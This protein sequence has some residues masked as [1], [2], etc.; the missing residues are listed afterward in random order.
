MHSD[1]SNQRPL[2]NVSEG[3]CQPAWSPDGRTVLYISP[4]RAQADVYTNT[5]ASIYAQDVNAQGEAVGSASRLIAVFGGAFDPDWSISGI[6]YSTINP[7]RVRVFNP[8]SQ[9]TTLISAGRSQDSQPSWSGDGQ[10]LAVVNYSRDSDNNNIY[11]VFAD[12]SFNPGDTNPEQMTR[13]INARSPAWSPNNRWL[14]YILDQ[15]VWVVPWDSAGF[16]AKQITVT[17]LARDPSWSP[18]SQWLAFDGIRPPTTT[19][20]WSTPPAG[21]CN[22]SPTIRHGIINRPGGPACSPPKRAQRR[23][24]RVPSS[25]ARAHGVGNIGYTQTVFPLEPSCTQNFWLF[26]WFVWL[27]QGC[28]GLPTP[29][30]QPSPSPWMM[31]MLAPTPSSP[32]T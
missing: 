7:Y 8:L 18:D 26:W 6:A 31:W 13:L 23:A 28:V 19:S 27:W 9:T 25:P 16:D 21:H 4:C 32:P 14:A 10:R 3:A 29:K 1:G 20:T 17:G 22:A 11:W 12:G 30:A 15:N 5:N 2:T 24:R